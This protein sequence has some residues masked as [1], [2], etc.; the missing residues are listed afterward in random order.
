M[1]DFISFILIESSNSKNTKE[2]KKS[3]ES[4]NIPNYE[5]IQSAL[6]TG[7]EDSTLNAICSRAKKKYIAII[8]GNI[9]LSKNW[10][11]KIKNEDCYDLF[12]GS[13]KNFRGKRV[14]D[15]FCHRSNLNQ[16]PLVLALNYQE[17]APDACLSPYLLLFSKRVWSNNSFQSTPE[18]NWSEHFCL[19]AS[20]AGYRVGIFPEAEAILRHPKGLWG[21][22]DETPHLSKFSESYYHLL[23][24]AK[25]SFEA[26]QFK[27][28]EEEYLKLSQSHANN[29]LIQNQLGWC[30]FYNKNYKKAL[31]SF[32]LAL[33]RE[34]FDLSAKR[35][36]AWSLFHLGKFSDAAKAFRKALELADSSDLGLSQDLYRG[37][38]W[39]LLRNSE[40]DKAI[41]HFQKALECIG[42]SNESQ[43]ND[44][45][46]G[47]HLCESSKILKS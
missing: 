32:N 45:L 13:I 12:G 28:A 47:L 10:Y 1:I 36:Q 3:I 35:G 14:L 40:G 46:K 23:M 22:F 5:I 2:C 43:K 44:A 31:D 37:L 33:S 42:N 21:L 27:K 15:W 25:K 26:N 41:S 11:A 18:N 20:K 24:R 39:A 8:D 6:P 34:A 16:E 17:W 7:Q 38:G 9:L 19:A 4:Q 30:F 29:S